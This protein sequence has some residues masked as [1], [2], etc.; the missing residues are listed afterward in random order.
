MKTEL[1]HDF[2]YKDNVSIEKETN[3]LLVWAII[4]SVPF[5]G[6]ALLMIALF[7]D[8]LLF[9]AKF[10]RLIFITLKHLVWKRT[11]NLI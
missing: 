10:I 2:E 7:F 6:W 3:S 1:A 8:L 11:K 5:I 4:W 9:I